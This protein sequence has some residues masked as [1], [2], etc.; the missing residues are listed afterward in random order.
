MGTG[1][2]RMKQGCAVFVLAALA[3]GA[4]YLCS[5]GAGGLASLF[6][7][8]FDGIATWFTGAAGSVFVIGMFT[9]FLSGLWA[10]IGMLDS[11]EGK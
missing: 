10:V 4:A 2:E 3:M 6:H 1:Q 9:L 7:G 11:T 5:A 8:P